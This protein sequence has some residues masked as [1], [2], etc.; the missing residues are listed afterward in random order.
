MRLLAFSFLGVGPWRLFFLPPLSLLFFLDLDFFFLCLLRAES[1]DQEELLEEA[2]EL[3][4][5]LLL[6]LGEEEYFL[7]DLDLFLLCFLDLL[8]R[9]ELLL[10]LRERERPR[11]CLRYFSSVS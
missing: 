10:R 7:F 4:S 8:L 5:E 2:E 9:E 11:L 1:E 6:E 3:L